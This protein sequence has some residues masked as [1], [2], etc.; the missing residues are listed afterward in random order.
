MKLYILRFH[1]I[2]LFECEA[3]DEDEILTRKHRISS[4]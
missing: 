1:I 3:G 2:S 4:Y